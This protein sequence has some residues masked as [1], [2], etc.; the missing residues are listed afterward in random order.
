MM[1]GLNRGDR[2]IVRRR[3]TEIEPREYRTATVLA[4]LDAG[5]ELV[6]DGSTRPRMVPRSRIVGVMRRGSAIRRWT[7]LSDR[8]LSEAYGV[9]DAEAVRTM[10]I[11]GTP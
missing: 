2:V 6:F 4:L 10:P 3:S 11:W 8:D 1:R 7:T 9:S 5:V